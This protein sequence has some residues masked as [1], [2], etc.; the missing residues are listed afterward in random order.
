VG[1]SGDASGTGAERPLLPPLSTEEMRVLAYASAIGREFDFA[2]LG[3]AMDAPDEAL[4]EQL[5]RMTHLGVLR[6]RPGGDRFAFVQD[7]V[8]ARV[9]QGLTASR[10]RVIHRKVAEA[11][12]RLYPEPPPEIVPELGR[13]YFLGKVP[14]KSH[15][16][17]RRAAE[18]ARHNDAPEEAAHHLERAWIDLRALPG[19]RPGEEAEL[20]EELGTLYYSLG[21][22]RAADR[23][24]QEGLEKAKEPAR[25]ARLYLARAE[26]A[27]DDLDGEAGHAA[28]RKAE[29]LFQE[30]GDTVGLASVHR[31]LGR[32]SF[33]RGEYREA[34]DQA[35]LALDLLQH[36]ADSRTL[37]RLCI[38]LGNAFSMLGPE[39]REDGADWYRR[40]IARLT[41]SGDWSEVARAYLNLATLVGQTNPIDGL[42]S[43]EK[44]REFAERAHE[45]RWAGW[46]LAM[47][48][49]MRL[50]LGQVEEAERDNQA[51]RRLL[52]RATDAL[53]LQQVQTNSGLIAERRGQWEDAEA[54]YHSSIA[55]AEQAGLA[56]EAAQSEFY[57]ARLLFKTR[58]I[59][60]ARAAYDRAAAAN[61][62]A[63]NPPSAR[64]FAELGRQLEAAR[65]EAERADDAS[66]AG[67]P[68]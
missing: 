57:L 62:P 14:E 60:A 65:R 33:H 51:A 12:E 38:D 44:G 37:G 53:G 31:V 27:R 2:L 39:V 5:E 58:D 16:Y 64:P 22:V 1:E 34:L 26:V 20:A 61:L 35:M 52:E 24:F 42:E 28:A 43:L 13:H 11:M 7:E 41:E 47:G 63:L 50:Q 59:A 36:V 18:V 8:R 10:L 46:G 45:P 25:R 48:V 54:A 55:L 15:L 29:V 49:E 66:G 40:A 9:Y 19:E 68:I 17:N 4:A 67:S 3:A 23:M 56:A 6:E 30:I 32:I 21:D